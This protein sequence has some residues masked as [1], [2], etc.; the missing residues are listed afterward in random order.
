MGAIQ[1][2]AESAVKIPAGTNQTGSGPPDAAPER[3]IP[4]D[5]ARLGF[6]AADE[7]GVAAELARAL[8]GR[9]VLGVERRW[10][11]FDLPHRSCMANPAGG[12]DGV[13]VRSERRH[14]VPDP[15]FW[16][17]LAPAGEAMRARGNRVAE[18]YRLFRVRLRPGLS[19]ALCAEIA[20]LPAPH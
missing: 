3:A 7:Y 12:T 10:A 1:S 13:L 14:D 2:G 20:L 9:V 19:P 17:V 8:P 5:T 18:R 16:V 6:I 4:A 11:L 15:R